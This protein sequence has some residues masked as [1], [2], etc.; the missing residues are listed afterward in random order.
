MNTVEWEGGKRNNFKTIWEQEKKKLCIINL[1]LKLQEK[2]LSTR[3][4][5]SCNS[6][7]VTKSLIGGKVELDLSL[8]CEL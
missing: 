1:D 2:W 8:K 4:M 7:I 3:G 5:K 6:V